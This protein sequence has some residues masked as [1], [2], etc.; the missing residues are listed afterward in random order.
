[1]E[2]NKELGGLIGPEDSA[3]ILAKACHQPRWGV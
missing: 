3:R 2:H 1:M